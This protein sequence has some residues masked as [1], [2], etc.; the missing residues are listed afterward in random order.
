MMLLRLFALQVN[1]R[2]G[3][4]ALRVL[5]REDPKKALRNAL[6]FAAVAL[7]L[8]TLLGMYIWLLHGMLPGFLALGMQDVFLGI[9]FLVMMVSVCLLGM[10]YLLGML[11]F[12]K[13]A[14]FLASLPLSQRTVFAAK[15]GQVLLSEIATGAL[16]LLPA[17]ILYGQATGAGVL[18]Y[19][20]ALLTVVFAPCIPLAL[21]GLLSLLLMRFNAL[22]R[23]RDVMTVLGS[24]VLVVLIMVAQQSIIAHIPENMSA[25]SMQALLTDASALLTP[26]SAAFPPSAWAA[27][28]VTGDWASLALF[29]LCSLAALGLVGLAAGR[30]YYRGAMAQLE[31]ASTK[32]RRVRRE[33]V[34]QHSPIMAQ[35][36]REWRILLRTPVYALNGLAGVVMLPLILLLPFALG[37]L[38]QNEELVQITQALLNTVDS[39]V[40][41]LILAAIMLL[42]G[43][44]NAA[45]TTTISR[46]GK[47]FYMLRMLPMSAED[48]ITA[49]YLMGLTITVIAVVFIVPAAYFGLG[50][51]WGQALF[52]MLLGLVAGAAPLALSMLPDTLRPKLHWNTETESIKQNAN[53]MLGMLIA[54]GYT[55]ALGFAVYGLLTTGISSGLLIVGLFALSI[56]TGFAALALLRRTARSSFRRV[57]G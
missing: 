52:A 51:S 21:S 53:G 25:E 50:V 41:V 35:Y 6:I 33:G 49:K 56:A 4:S 7:S 28:G 2:L 44:I 23:H 27:R 24:L 48:Q 36:L 8:S 18:F 54:S 55:V 57:E 12:A 5:W 19:L 30:L 43:I 31:T 15:F 40:S 42:M 34:R 11:F 32:R 26:L 38:P 1:Q 29:L 20:R 3:L 46:E 10:V 13:D 47:A 45:A 37:S 16:F 14:E 17:L 39:G 9:V 22:W